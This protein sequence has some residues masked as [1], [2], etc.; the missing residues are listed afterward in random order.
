MAELVSPFT[1]FHSDLRVYNGGTSSVIVTPTFYPQANGTPVTGLS[2]TLPAGQVKSIDNALPTLFNVPSGGGSIVFTTNGN[3]NLVTTGRTYTNA[4]GGG[5]FG[6]FI[7][8]VAPQQGIGVGSAPLQVLQL[9]ESQNFRSNLGLA[10]LT[11]NPA[12]V[13]IT[14]TVPDSKIAANVELDLA[15]NEFRQLG[16]VLAGMFPGQQ[17]YN[18]RIAVQVTSGTGRVT[19]YGSVIDNV[20]KDPTY[21]PAQ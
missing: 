14:A 7:P 6:Q 5:T 1:N 4:D 16:S 8:G 12:H 13:K 9:E 10:E 21:V 17:V 11:G 15:A 20:S 19:A 18:A 2:F 3:S